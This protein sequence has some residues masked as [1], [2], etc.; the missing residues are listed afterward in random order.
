MK[1]ARGGRGKPPFGIKV[2]GWRAYRGEIFVGRKSFSGEK[3]GKFLVL[4]NGGVCT[5][6]EKKKDPSSEQ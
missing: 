5:R 1:R 6:K 3:G 4:Q 2:S